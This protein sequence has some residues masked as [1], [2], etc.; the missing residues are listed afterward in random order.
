MAVCVCWKRKR[1]FLRGWKVF[2]VMWRIP[3]GDTNTIYVIYY[4]KVHVLGS[5]CHL[6]L[7]ILLFF[8]SVNLMKMYVCGKLTC[9]AIYVVWKK[10]LLKYDG[11]YLFYKSICICLFSPVQR[12]EIIYSVC[13]LMTPKGMQIADTF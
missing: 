1:R 9:T 7:N 11:D 8:H 12:D 4:N 2:S 13:F 5:G 10:L 6:K 3:C